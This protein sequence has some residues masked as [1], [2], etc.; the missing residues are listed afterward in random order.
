MSDFLSGKTAVVTGAS[1]GL[2]RAIA[3]ALGGEGV[4]V[5]LVARDAGKLEETACAVRA[6][7]GEAAA[8][9]ADLTRE[10][11][12]AQLERDVL[13]RFGAVQILVNNAGVN[14][15]KPLVDF[16]LDEWRGVMDG[17]HTSAFLMC[18]AFVPH[19]KGTGYGRI[20]N[21]SSIMGHISLPERAAYSSS[22][23]ALLGLTRALALELAPEGITV[24]AISPGPCS[25]E[26]NA[27]ILNDPEWNA[28]FLARIPVQRW[29]RPEDIGAL[30]A[31]I[32]SEAAEFITGTDILIDGGWT[33]Q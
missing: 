20:I 4:R 25:T 5:A 33:A 9:T 27:P 13:A 32:C 11:Q 15:R 21:L 18:R 14:L 31:F 30:A 17:N 29:G 26:M 1:R 23:A 16:S 12:V 19:M 28:S 7:G 2:G 3:V 10:D 6:A 8:F 22:K 24:V